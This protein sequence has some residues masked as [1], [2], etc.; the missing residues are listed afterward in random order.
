MIIEFSDREGMVL[1]MSEAIF[2]MILVCLIGGAVKMWENCFC[3]W[4]I[5]AHYIQ[6]LC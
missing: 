6:L 5:V 4:G 3:C 1:K 2:G